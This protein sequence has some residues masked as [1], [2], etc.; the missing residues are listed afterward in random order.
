MTTATPTPQTLH[1]IATTYA[2]E[3]DIY[4]LWEARAESR[5]QLL[6]LRDRINDALDAVEIYEID[7]AIALLNAARTQI[8]IQLFA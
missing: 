5:R 2:S 3:E 8:N 7:E 1:L 4:N 6:A